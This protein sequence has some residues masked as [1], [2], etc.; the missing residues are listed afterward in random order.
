MDA[1]VDK[2]QG[3]VSQEAMD[4]ASKGGTGFTDA[5]AAAKNG[6]GL[7]KRASYKIISKPAVSIELELK[8]NMDPRDFHKK[9]TALQD[10]ASRGK[11]S[12]A[13]E[14]IVR[15]KNFPRMYRKD[16][17]KRAEALWGE[18]EPWRVDA[19]KKSLKN[20]D[21][22]HLQDMQLN[23]LDHAFNL[24]MLDR[25]TNAS[26]GPQIMHQLKNVP[27]GTKIKEVIIKNVKGSNN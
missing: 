14:S 7:T 16:I 19:L 24:G 6:S 13:P 23:G 12:V 9:V 21:V 20:K 10:L 8:P 26:L 11:L 18:S 3:I 1:L 22:D 5:V 27:E 2:V 4:Q 15:N 17:V 25:A